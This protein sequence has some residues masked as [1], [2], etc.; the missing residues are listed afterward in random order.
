M[1]LSFGQAVIASEGAALDRPSG[2]SMLA[3]IQTRQ[4]DRQAFDGNRQEN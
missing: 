3:G 1:I 2:Q 4:A